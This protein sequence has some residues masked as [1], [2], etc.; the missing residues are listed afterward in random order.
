MVNGQQNELLQLLLRHDFRQSQGRAGGHTDP[1]KNLSCKGSNHD[2]V[3]SQRQGSAL[4]KRMMK[5]DKKSDNYGKW[6]NSARQRDYV[7][8]Q[9]KIGSVVCLST[10][11]SPSMPEIEGIYATGDILF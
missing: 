2:S 5:N 10:P 1:G 4:G 3:G 6:N 11:V 9:I 8:S 7:R